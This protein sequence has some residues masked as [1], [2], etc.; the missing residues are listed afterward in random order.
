MPGDKTVLRMASFYA[1]IWD[2]EAT[3][4]WVGKIE[5]EFI[6]ERARAYFLCRLSKRDDAMEAAKRALELEPDDPVALVI[7]AMAYSLDGRDTKQV[8]IYVQR[9]LTGAPENGLVT[10]PGNERRAGRN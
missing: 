3:V 9:A 7:Q 4:Q 5:D 6:V 1:E 8:D 2:L 10:M